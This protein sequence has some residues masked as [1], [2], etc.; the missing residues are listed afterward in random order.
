LQDEPVGEY[1]EPFKINS[2]RVNQAE[3]PEVDEEDL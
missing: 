2:G 1:Q 3:L